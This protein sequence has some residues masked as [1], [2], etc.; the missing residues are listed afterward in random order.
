VF[1]RP[2]EGDGHVLHG[3]GQQDRKRH[4]R[5]D[6]VGVIAAVRVDDVRIGDEPSG[7]EPGRQLVNHGQGVLLQLDHETRGRAE[8]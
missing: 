5:L 6:Q 4:A 2:G 1:V 3:V 8:A 7:V